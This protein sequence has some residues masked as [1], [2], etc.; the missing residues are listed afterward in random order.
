M[1]TPKPGPGLL[2][3]TAIVVG[4]NGWARCSRTTPGAIVVKCGPCPHPD[5][6]DAD[7]RCWMAFE[8]SIAL[9]HSKL[10]LG[11][12]SPYRKGWLERALHWFTWHRS[13]A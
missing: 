2:A 1:T 13:R 9:A 7:M 4:V 3:G 5:M 8:E 12:P 10:Y 11:M 6:C